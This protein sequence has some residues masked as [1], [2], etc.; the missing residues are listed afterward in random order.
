MYKT[1]GKPADRKP[2]N[3]KRGNTGR[4][5]EKGDTRKNTRKGNQTNMQTVDAKE[6]EGK[7]Q[8]ETCRHAE[9]KQTKANKQISK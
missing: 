2:G 5:H 3:T 9:G 6:T 4:R 8:R 7:Q 1:V